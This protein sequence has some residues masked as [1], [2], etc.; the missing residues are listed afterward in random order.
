MNAADSTLRIDNIAFNSSAYVLGA[1]AADNNQ[2]ISLFAHDKISGGI[3][4][5]ADN[6]RSLQPMFRGSSV[7]V[8]HI[9]KK[10]VYS[11]IAEI[12]RDNNI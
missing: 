10:Q 6:L 4:R 9:K 1:V 12:D 8:A 11:F 3:Y 2:P 7:K 5:L